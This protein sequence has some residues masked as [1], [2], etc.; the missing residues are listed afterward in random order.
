MLFALVLVIVFF[1]LAGCIPRP[2]L[3]DR[4][5]ELGDILMSMPGVES[6]HA[7]HQNGFSTGRF[8]Q[9]R[10]IMESGATS[11]ATSASSHSTRAH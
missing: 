5:E 2:D 9:H 1:G 10:V 4:A 6:V 11:M 3:D 7:Q 8:L